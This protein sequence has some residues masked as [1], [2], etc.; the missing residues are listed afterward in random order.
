MDLITAG[1]E[2]LL[3]LDGDLTGRVIV[4]KHTALN[5]RYQSP[6]F[7]LF[8][9]T[10]GFGCQAGG[11]G[12]AVFVRSLAD[13]EDGRYNRRDFVG[14]ASDALVNQAMADTTPIIDIDLTERIYL[15]VAKDGTHELGETIDQAR[16]RL[17]MI[18]GSPVKDVYHIHPESTITDFGLIHFPKGASPTVVKIKKGTIWTDISTT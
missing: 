17:K 5:R 6:R 4:L 15:V 2:G 3:P 10:G 11:L 16:K 7:Q 1:S 18:T 12:R 9:A 14:I 8:K 13:S